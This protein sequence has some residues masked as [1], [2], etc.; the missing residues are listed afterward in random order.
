[1][2]TSPTFGITLLTAGQ[3]GAELTVNEAIGLLEAAA[4][5]VVHLTG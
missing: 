1:M 5:G 4:V 2:T 3:A